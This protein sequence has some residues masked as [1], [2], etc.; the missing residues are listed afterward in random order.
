MA[1]G[2]ALEVLDR[3]TAATSFHGAAAAGRWRN[4]RPTRNT[5]VLFGLCLVSPLKKAE[6]TTL[7]CL[8]ISVYANIKLRVTNLKA[9]C[10][11][12]TIPSSRVHSCLKGHW[13]C[14]IA[15]LP[16]AE[17]FPDKLVFGRCMMS[18]FV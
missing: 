18:Y 13:Q 15:Q 5:D 6:N 1:V 11:Q 9:R 8:R 2:Q 12:F 14:R 17:S 16:P 4:I 3:P 10:L 7:G